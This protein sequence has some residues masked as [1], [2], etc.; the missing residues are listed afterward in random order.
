MQF[1]IASFL[2]IISFILFTGSALAGP[3]TFNVG[4]FTSVG[5]TST[6]SGTITV[7]DANNDSFVSPSEIT[8]WTFTSSIYQSSTIASTQSE[9]TIASLCLPNCFRISHGVLIAD[10]DLHEE[11]IT[12][13]V[14]TSSHF[15]DATFN[16]NQIDWTDTDQPP[17]STQLNE[18]QAKDLG[19]NYIVGTSQVPE[20]APITLFGVALIAYW[21]RRKLVSHGAPCAAV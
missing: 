13:F 8:T 17:T 5:N 11:A 18:G 16:A 9:S 15:S 12:F 3:V 14:H 10:L 6:L 2:F 1:R 19:V 4:T 20:P 21:V 7:N